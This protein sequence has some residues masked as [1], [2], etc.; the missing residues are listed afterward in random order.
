MADNIA[1]LIEA[2]KQ[3]TTYVNS[4]YSAIVSQVDNSGTV[5]VYL[6]GSSIETPTA[7][8]SSEVHAGDHVT[9]E[10]R[11]NKL[12]IA[13]N[14]S[15]PSAGV[16]R[17]GAVE[18]VASNAQAAAS[19]AYTAANNAQA[20]AD[21]AHAAADEAEGHAQTAL[22]NAGL[23]ATAASNAQTSAT[24][25][26]TSADSALVSLATVEDVVGVL[27]WITAHG[28][29]TP[30]GSTALDPSKV[31]FV[32]DA[33]GDYEVSGT[34]YSVVA[35]PKAEDR[36]SYY[37]LSVDESVQNY[38]ATHVTVNSEGMWLIPDQNGTPSTNGKKILIATGAGTYTA[39]TYIIDRSSGTDKV[40]ASFKADSIQI[41]ESDNAHMLIK[42]DSQQIV[43]SLGNVFYEIGVGT[44]TISSG[45]SF[46]TSL[47]D[48]VTKDYN[49]GQIIARIESV[50]V[51]NVL[52][53]EGV[54]YT[55][56]GSVLS[57]TTAP[58]SGS[59]VDVYYRPYGSSTPINYTFGVR[60]ETEPKGYLSVCEGELCVASGSQ[61]HAEGSNTIAEGEN[62]H[63]EG[64]HTY[65]GG[66][67]SHAEG[68][69]TQANGKGSHASGYNTRANGDYQTVIGKH[70]LAYNPDTTYAF[71]IGNG[72]GGSG[73]G[74]QSNA[75]TVEWTGNVNIPSGAKYQIN[76][77]NLSASDVGALP[78]TGGSISGNLSLSG[79]I[80]TGGHSSAIGTVKYAQLT[81]N[82]SVSSGTGTELCSFSLEA[83]VWVINAGV[84]WA[85]NSSGW[86]RA[87][88]S[89]TSGATD[90]Q[91]VVAPVNGEYTQMN[92]SRILEL[93]STTTYYLNGY[94]NTGSAL[95][96]LGSS[97]T[98][99]GTF[100]TAV[101]I[102]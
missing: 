26:Q 91:C 14:Y 20:D 44:P 58:A 10:W 84:R 65:A 15:N 100:M 98:N 81:S 23:A 57:F 33:N 62:S 67:A 6:A 96:A 72:N 43:D 22:T 30:N 63:A 76:G 90:I 93:S 94:Q 49:L 95:N 66:D 70:N 19:V 82:K 42:Q 85:T 53:T 25:A 12:Y 56:H 46:G 75:F 8:T 92:F 18:T 71:I 40:L 31:Y 73:S 83:G 11:N 52:K 89:N 4:T 80:T 60:L 1:E 102:A 9:V 29:M 48:G 47:T 36:T 7:S 27:N 2:F 64:E 74:A 38:V 13:G 69:G 61:S 78:T 99:Y 87:N 17:V 54:D 86:R 3:D 34:H 50:K 101:R 79:T 32:V 28:T 88:I 59:Y 39:G 97:G 77:T 51:D 45:S 21:R 16:T 35:E 24:N 55:F 37:T 41:G 5:W 68:I